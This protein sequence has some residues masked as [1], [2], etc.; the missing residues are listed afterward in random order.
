MYAHLKSAAE[1]QLLIAVLS[2]FHMFAPYIV[3]V[4]W[5]NCVRARGTYRPSLAFERVFRDET[6]CSLV[7]QRTYVNYIYFPDVFYNSC[8]A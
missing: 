3:S 8:E 1:L 4:L 6:I 2:L 5:N 7:L